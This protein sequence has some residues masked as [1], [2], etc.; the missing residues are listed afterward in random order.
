MKVV[1]PIRPTGWR[2]TY[3]GDTVSLH[4]S[5]GNWSYPCRSHYWIR[6]NHAIP[7]GP[8][9]QEA[10]ESGRRRDCA[11]KDAYFGETPAAVQ[12]QSADGTSKK[13][14]SFLDWLLGR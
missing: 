2:L 11:A 5:V 1:R 4:P 8:M 9:P 14:W 3:D 6:S 12:V 7:A 10:I 13:R